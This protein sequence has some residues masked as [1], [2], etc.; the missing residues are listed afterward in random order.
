MMGCDEGFILN[1]LKRFERAGRSDC[2]VAVLFFFFYF[3]HKGEEGDLL[4]SS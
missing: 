4:I 3:S 1:R 2:V